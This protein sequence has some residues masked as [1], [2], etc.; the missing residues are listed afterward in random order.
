MLSR[1]AWK[2]E[3][4]LTTCNRTPWSSMFPW[5]VMAPLTFITSASG[6]TSS[7][8]CRECRECRFFRE[9]HFFLL[10]FRSIF[11]SSCQ[12][13]NWSQVDCLHNNICRC[14]SSLHPTMQQF[15]CPDS[16]DPSSFRENMP[17]TLIFSYWK[18]ASWACF[19]YENWVYKFGH[20]MVTNRR[21]VDNRIFGTVTANWSSIRWFRSCHQESCHKRLS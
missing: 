5:H 19:H 18:W 4:F 20:W 17:K 6:F 1:S 13:I 9:R 21:T 10:I 14:V 16:L 8:M 15:L 11:L 3:M 2:M 7:S 12:V